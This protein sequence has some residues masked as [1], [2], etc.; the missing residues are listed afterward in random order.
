MADDYGDDLFYLLEKQSATQRVSDLDGKDAMP[1]TK[2]SPG[3]H[4][5]DLPGSHF[6]SPVCGAT[7][8]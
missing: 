3:K 5:G 8:L 1:L 7:A 6:S 2:S 4:S